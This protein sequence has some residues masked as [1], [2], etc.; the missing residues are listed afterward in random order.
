VAADKPVSSE[1]KVANVGAVNT[2]RTLT[3]LT[4]NKTVRFPQEASANLPDDAPL[5]GTPMLPPC[6]VVIVFLAP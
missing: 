4:A 6:P 5:Q 2:E 3:A 1:V